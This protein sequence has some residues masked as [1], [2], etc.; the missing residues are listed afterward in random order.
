MYLNYS[1][2]KLFSLLIRNIIHYKI[3]IFI[4]ISS[5]V[6]MFTLLFNKKLAKYV[7][8]GIDI[9]L[10]FII[11]VKYGNNLLRISNFKY[12]Y[13][14]MY[15]YFFNS[16]IF[17]IINLIMIFKNKLLNTSII[18]FSISFIFLAF[19]LF[20]TYYLY[21]T[22]IL[23]LG[24]IYSEYVIGNYLYFIYYIIALISIFLTK[25]KHV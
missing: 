21:N 18:F 6:L 16:I 2:A 12:F 5:L 3:Y 15:F 19:C 14:N 11:V 20:M 13:H 1:I 25:R 10:S 24:N 7:I 22:H 8:L 17:M 23:L 9:I 4:I